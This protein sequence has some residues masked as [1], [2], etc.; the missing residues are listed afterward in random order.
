MS[1]A[2]RIPAGPLLA[3][4]VVLLSVLAGAGGFAAGDIII[5][6]LAAVATIPIAVTCAAMAVAPDR[7]RATSIASVA[8]PPA[9]VIAFI[10]AA[11]LTSDPLTGTETSTGSA[12]AS[13]ARATYFIATFAAILFAVLRRQGRSSSRDL[14]VPLAW[15]IGSMIATIVLIVGLAGPGW[16]E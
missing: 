16:G 10:A 6:F 15:G 5:G 13:V 11:S 8:G 7:R 14:W 12:L 1:P 9:V 4:I 2:R 3:A